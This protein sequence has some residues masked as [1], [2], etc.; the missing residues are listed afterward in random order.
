MNLISIRVENIGPFYGEHNFNLQISTEKNLILI[1]G[2]NG[3]GKTTLLTALKYC[4]FGSHAIG[5]Q[6]TTK[7]YLDGIK[8]FLNKRSVENKLNK[9]SIKIKYTEVNNLEKQLVC[10]TRKWK[11]LKADLS[12]SYTISINDKLLSDKEALVYLNNLKAKIHPSLLTSL[13]FDGEKIAVILDEGKI[14]L[15]LQEIL[16][17]AFNI[18][19][20]QSM[21]NDLNQFISIEAEKSNLTQDEIKLLEMRNGLKMIQGEEKALRKEMVEWISNLEELEVK[22]D[23]LLVEYSILGGLSDSQSKDLKTKLAGIEES[24]KAN[25]QK[26][27]D[28]LDEYYSFA[29][30]TTLLNSGKERILEEFLSKVYEQVQY[31][32]DNVDEYHQ[33]DAI[34]Q[35]LSILEDKYMP[36]RL[37]DVDQSTIHK[38][39][40]IFK[41]LNNGLSLS[42]MKNLLNSIFEERDISSIYRGKLS[43]SEYKELEQKY[44]SILKINNDIQ[45]AKENINKKETEIKLLNSTILEKSQELHSFENE[46]F[47]KIKEQNSFKIANKIIDINTLF[48]AKKKEKILSDLEKMITIKFNNV[49]RK[50][51]F[52][53]LIEINHHTFD[54]TLKR[55]TGEIFTINNLS[56]G[57]KQVLIACIILSVYELSRKSLPFVFDTPLARLDSENRKKFIQEI[58]QKA[59]KQVIIL[60]TDE[61]ITPKYHALLKPVIN[62][63]YL[64][65]ND[66]NISTVVTE[67][68]YFRGDTNV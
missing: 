16:N 4:L 5:L 52:I 25:T 21:N 45:I 19:L 50:E 37:H 6:T 30:N 34:V 31:Y 12:E 17:N 43:D 29:I 53:D 65:K 60:S 56:A 18:S 54:L 9:F 15:Y 49:I 2:K 3:S 47:S 33:S 62:N 41:E 51:D 36:K 64:M 28:F 61:E 68:D 66:G 32:S 46:V 35:L 23:H 24:K 42:I 20:F 13:M 14:N 7:K 22:K 40:F 1:G 38:I 10:I 59:S 57:E 58:I 48:I 44:K 39:D 8:S 27:D 11:F 26:L 63:V 55:N 67:G